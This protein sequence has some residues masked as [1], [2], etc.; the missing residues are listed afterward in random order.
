M[1][2]AATLLA[3]AITAAACASDTTAP[4]A[5]DASLSRGG[6]TTDPTA[7]WL[8]PLEASGLALRSDGR[9]PSNGNS[10]Y[11]NGVCG[12]TAKIFA[13]TSSSSGDATITMD[14]P[15]GKNGCGRTVTLDY[16]NGI[17]ETLRTFANVRA[18]QNTVI[19]I[20]LGDTEGRTFAI[21]P[22]ALNSNTRCGRLVYGQN[23]TVAVGS[24]SV[25]VTRLSAT[26][27]RVETA[28]GAAKAW[29]ERRN[30]IVE[31]PIRFEIVSSS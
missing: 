5:E 11:A 20:P 3:I 31:M 19:S 30:E 18:L 8:I 29:C 16:G 17:T 10:L 27:W 12:V 23:G 15:S 4:F 9:Y 28:P 26:S 21:N 1:R 6:G 7:T 22:G 14:A 2:T 25:R 24:D 13:A